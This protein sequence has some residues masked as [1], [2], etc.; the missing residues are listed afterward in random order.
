MHK[1]LI[2]MSLLLLAA[3]AFAQVTVYSD[4]ESVFIGRNDSIAAIF[5]IENTSD[6][7]QCLDL[8]GDTDSY[9]IEIEPGITEVCLPKN[10]QTK[11]TASVKSIDAPAANFEAKL[12]A[13][14][15]NYTESDFVEVKILSE[16]EIE[17][18]EYE[19]DICRAEDDYFS[20]LVKNNSNELKEIR[21]WADNEMLLPYFEPSK[22][23]LDAF[24]DKYVK[25]YVHTGRNSLLGDYRVSLFAEDG[26]IVSKKVAFIPVKD[27]ENEEPEFSISLSTGC[28]YVDREDEER[29][30][31][32]IRNLEDEELEL[33]VAI[34]SDLPVD[35]DSRVTLEENER[36]TFN[37]YINARESDYF[38]R[39]D[40][41]LTVWD[42]ETGKSIERTKCIYVRKSKASTVELLN[43]DIEISQCLS[44][45]FTLLAKNTGDY[46][47]NYE[48]TINEDF[49][50][51]YINVSVSEDEFELGEDEQK[52]I[53]IYVTTQKGTP[54]GNYEFDIIVR[55][56]GK[57]M[58][59][60]ARFSVTEKIESGELE[61]VSYPI[62]VTVPDGNELAIVV[63]LRNG[64]EE[65]VTVES[66]SLL[67]L[68]AEF[69]VNTAHTILIKA[70]KT[71]TVELALVSGAEPG[72]YN[73][74][75]EVKTSEFAIVENIEILVPETEEEIDVPAEE[76]EDDT[77][78]QFLAGLY[79][80]G[81]NVLYGIGTLA[82]ALLIIL[83]ATKVVRSVGKN[84]KEV[85][86]GRE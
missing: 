73:A 77:D 42:P 26:S 51:G 17:L 58:E 83:L 80:A 54:L 52:E 84:E 81:G 45:V 7:E 15:A 40:F 22:L 1:T 10:S 23:T 5:T 66:V 46:E 64:T 4:A 24:E 85:W 72:T 61:V 75:L 3:S 82:I 53:Y 18:V 21:L 13:E 57:R 14:N 27:C 67:G 71:R 9:Y 55:H 30:S 49:N 6:E 78:E 11:V 59:K 34:E 79:T 43:N 62:Q 36:R 60:T 38:G 39:H 65:D 47:L 8:S 48:I 35:Y 74:T 28:T 19:A 63:S 86:M 16:P 70:G 41:D 2:S 37:A 20:V 29:I 50:T 68:P 76:E 69:T 33:R 56:N 25:V 32:S 44:E 31:F 12:I